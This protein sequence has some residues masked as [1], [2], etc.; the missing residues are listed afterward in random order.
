ML[1]RT[2]FDCGLVGLFRSIG[3]VISRTVRLLP[4]VEGGVG[5]PQPF[6]RLIVIAAEV[7]SRSPRRGHGPIAGRIAVA[8][9]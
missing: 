2:L 6:P 7:S 8:G 4:E 1:F 3:T 5:R 9:V